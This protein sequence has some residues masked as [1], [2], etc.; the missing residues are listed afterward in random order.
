MAAAV[1]EFDALADAVGTAAQDHHFAALFGLHLVFGGHLFKGAVGAQALQGPLVGGVVVRRAGGK[2]GGTGVHGLEHG[3]DAEGLAVAAHLQLV[4]AGGPGELAIR[5]A[6][7]LE[8]QQ[9][10]SFELL[11]APAP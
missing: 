1:V 2:L 3:V 11:E 9:G 10:R 4:A 5:E 6:Q 8:F 7:L